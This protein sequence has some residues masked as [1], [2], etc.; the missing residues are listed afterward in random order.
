MYNWLV[1][2]FWLIF[3]D[4]L[5]NIIFIYSIHIIFVYVLYEFDDKM[6]NLIVKFSDN[7]VKIDTTVYL[8]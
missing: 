8:L 3:F 7:I 6:I 1:N 4:I 2:Q 5:I